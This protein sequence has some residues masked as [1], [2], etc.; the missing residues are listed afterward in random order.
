MKYLRNDKSQKAE[1]K[2]RSVLDVSLV[3]PIIPAGCFIPLSTIF[4]RLLSAFKLLNAMYSTF[5]RLKISERSSV[6]M[7]WGVPGWEDLPQS[8]PPKFQTF[9]LELNASK[10]WNG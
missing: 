3:L 10:F 9:K 5:E 4:L 7:K 2:R 6:G 8:G 1:I